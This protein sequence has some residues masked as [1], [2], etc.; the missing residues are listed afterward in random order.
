[1]RFASA[2]L[3]IV[4]AG[5][6]WG[7]KLEPASSAEFCGRCHR[8]ILEAWKTSA[9]A[10]AM[11]SPIFQEG[12]EM[13]AAS[14]GV[15]SDKVCLACHAPL[16]ALIQD[17]SLRQKVS[18]EGITCDY[19]HSVRTVSLV[20]GNWKATVDLS[21][22]KTGPLKDVVAPSHGTQY[23]TVHTTSLICAPC[24]EYRNSL[25]F[26]VLTTYSEWEKSRYAKEGRDCQSC[27]MYQ[28]AGAV[29]DP[30]VKKTPEAEVNL[31]AMP[32]SHSIDQLN[33][34]IKAQMSTSREGDRLKVT[35]QVENVAA[36]HYVPTG[37]PMRQL[38]LE[39]TAAPF[40]SAEMRQER[41]YRRT[42][43][44]QQDKPVAFEPYAFLRGAKNVSDNR[45][46][47]D[48]RRVETFMFP[49]KAGV[50]AQVA[51]TFWYY[52]SPLAQTESQKRITFLNVRRLVR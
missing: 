11:E 14:L 39:V 12:L 48:E 52:Y 23:S 33:K 17:A 34:T 35:V 6:L 25:G 15:G 18:W 22:V 31:H 36:G 32:G 42:V 16:A 30:K 50:Q 7:Q 8:A 9:H 27:H 19:C 4:F 24:H 49:L 43:V 45:L 20:N 13:A 46:A 2:I 3:A 5:T 47:P 44:D 10:K 51:A 37:S 38:I 29:V 21:L 26:A 28:V 41:V 1:M 40:G